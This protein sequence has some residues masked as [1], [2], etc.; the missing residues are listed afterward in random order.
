MAE[1]TH[2]PYGYVW[3]DPINFSDPTGMVGMLLDSNAS[4]FAAPDR[5]GFTDNEVWVDNDG[6]FV[7]IPKA[8][9]GK[10][11]VTRHRLFLE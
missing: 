11:R 1:Y 10:E 3:N 5:P 2:D 4:F 7:S 8:N 6:V 9:Y